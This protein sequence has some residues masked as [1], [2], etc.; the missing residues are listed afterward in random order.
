[1]PTNNQREITK[2]KGEASDSLMDAD[3]HL[4]QGGIA[5]AINRT[6]IALQLLL[7]INDLRAGK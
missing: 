4:Q 1:M 3:T 6:E 2:L 7:R 5:H